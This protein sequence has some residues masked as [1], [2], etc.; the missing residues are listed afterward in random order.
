M[1]KIDYRLTIEGA[2]YEWVTSRAYESTLSDGRERIAGL[3]YSGL[4]ISEKLKLRDSDVTLSSM[5]AKVRHRRAMEI[6][7]TRAP[8]LSYL[9]ESCDAP[10]S[11]VS[12]NL[13]VASPSSFEVDDII[14]L[15]TEAC[16]VTAVESTYITVDGQQ[17]DTLKQ[18][19][20]MS[21]KENDTGIDTRIF[22]DLPTY[23][24]RRCYLFRYVDGAAS[25]ELDVDHTEDNL[26][27]RG[28]ISEAPTVDTD[29]L[30]WVI[31]IEPI[32]LMLEQEFGVSASALSGGIRGIHHS[33]HDA[34][35]IYA[36]CVN[37]D[38][39]TATEVGPWRLTGHWE[40]EGDFIAEVQSYMGAI[41]STSPFST[42]IE[43]LNFGI[44]SGVYKLSL[45]TKNTTWPDQLWFNIIIVGI[46]EGNSYSVNKNANHYTPWFVWNSAP[47]PLVL[48]PFTL[49]N[50]I[51]VAELGYEYSEPIVNYYS[52][53][54]MPNNLADHI[55][56]S[57][58]ARG[59]PRCWL[60]PPFNGTF[61]R[62]E[63]EFAVWTPG[64]L[65][66]DSTEAESNLRI[67]YTNDLGSYLSSGDY[68]SVKM[69]DYERTLEVDG[70]PNTTDRYFD[71]KLPDYAQFRWSGG[72][73][74]LN[75]SLTITY[76][77]IFLDES[78]EITPVLGSKNGNLGSLITMIWA[79]SVKANAGIAPFV[80][81]ADIANISDLDQCSVDWSGILDKY[82]L[83]RTYSYREGVPVR[84][85]LREEAKLYG[86][87]MCLNSY[88]KISFIELKPPSDL[89]TMVTIDTDDIVTPPA[90]GGMWPMW[91][92]NAEGIVNT[93]KISR[94]YHPGGTEAD[95]FTVREDESIS[96]Y[97][98]RSRA[99][100]SISPK[101]NKSLG[102]DLL[103][104]EAAKS[105]W[106][107]LR[108]LAHDY[109][110]ITI[111]VKSELMS[112]LFI[113]TAVSL[114]TPHV[115]NTAT[116]ELGITARKCMVIGREWELDPS[117]GAVG[118]ITLWT[119]S[120]TRTCGYAPAAHVI[121]AELVTG[122]VWDLSVS[123]NYY[124]D[125]G[126]DDTA[127]FLAGENVSIS[128]F[129]DAS[130]TIDYATIVSLSPT[131]MRVDFGET[132]VWSGTYPVGS[133]WIVRFDGYATDA[134]MDYAYVANY[135][136]RVFDSTEDAYELL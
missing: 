60:N 22:G 63:D 75:S 89:D 110:V 9:S 26:I 120:A 4:K 99:E 101:S 34:L 97:K 1:T 133:V 111:A 124:S 50:T 40:N 94:G 61:W 16:K 20:Y 122:Y 59:K 74:F 92:R 17:W 15:G 136:R 31:K 91:A 36:S 126:L 53:P 24:G 105:G 29:G 121:D 109:E 72:N 114:T 46:T 56:R 33:S 8:I 113:G 12:K 108:M 112:S 21:S 25:D 131:N 71:V 14:H 68:V 118:K 104:E 76:E 87:A 11:G 6:F 73:L 102:E 107:L 35:G 70:A 51:F 30:S 7:A 103:P 116:G 135:N 10:G 78:A 96:H 39:P 67:Y 3:Q 85:I 62:K 127:Y 65:S 86:I 45:K 93:V 43:T 5:S 49:D 64:D 19:H 44:E 32:T 83:Y 117:K 79:E 77:C 123:E 119:E 13:Y 37:N 115:P 125:I 128:K 98:N 28:V 134:M 2:P 82:L 69:P 132:P 48:L 84:E 100:A 41:A 47:N 54:S 23:E 80:T 95:P 66:F 58:L 52:L 130:E 38:V 88:G 90:P 81:S 129:N 106:K 57:R 27:W 55:A 18:N 42:Y